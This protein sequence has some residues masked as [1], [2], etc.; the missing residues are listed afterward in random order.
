M[1]RLPILIAF[2]G[3]LA[4]EPLGGFVHVDVGKSGTLGSQG[5][6]GWMGALST[7]YRIDPQEKLVALV[8]FQHVPIDFAGMARF[9]TLVYQS[10]N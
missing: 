2:C 8:F 10:L 3:T 5:D 9:S 6:F 4:A 1:I 7:W